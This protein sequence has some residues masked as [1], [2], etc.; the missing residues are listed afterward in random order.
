MTAV[1]PERTARANSSSSPFVSVPFCPF[2]DERRISEAP[3]AR[4]SNGQVNGARAI[5]NI[6]RPRARTVH[7]T[8][9]LWTTC[10]G[11]YFRK[12]LLPCPSANVGSRVSNLDAQRRSLSCN[13][14]GI[15]D[16]SVPPRLLG[17]S[18][19]RQIFP[20]REVV[21]ARCVYPV[22]FSRPKGD[23]PVCLQ[24]VMG[25]RNHRWS[26]IIYRRSGSLRMEDHFAIRR[27]QPIVLIATLAV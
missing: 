21:N 23:F 17:I 9:A 10:I 5:K 13:P 6:P 3:D 18:A 22:C 25:R 7:V 24:L 15:R 2:D 8:D 26:G 11:L 12:R 1:T 14:R 16:S 4:L 20:D 19:V 27:H